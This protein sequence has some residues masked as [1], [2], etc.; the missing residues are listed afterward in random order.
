MLV[1]LKCAAWV[2]LYNLLGAPAPCSKRIAVAALV[3]QSPQSPN[4]CP[5]VWT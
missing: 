1:C 4:F 3:W 5:A 2:K